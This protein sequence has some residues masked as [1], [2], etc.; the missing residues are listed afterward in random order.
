MR[1][2]FGEKLTTLPFTRGGTFLARTQIRH[3]LFWGQ[4][5]YRRQEFEKAAEIIK[6]CQEFVKKL[7]EYERT[8]KLGEWPHWGTRGLIAYFLGRVYR[9]Q[10]R[11][12]EA[13]A[14]FEESIYCYYQRARDSNAAMAAAYSHYRVAKA[15]ALGVGW[16]KIAEGHFRAALRQNLIP[17]SVLLKST[18]D[19]LNQ[20]RVLLLEV[21][22]ERALAGA[23]QAALMGIV[24]TLQTAMG[25]FHGHPHY[26]AKAARELCLAHVDLGQ[27]EDADAALRAFLA[28]RS[29]VSYE[30]EHQILS[31]L[32]A[33]GRFEKLGGAP[34]NASAAVD[35]AVKAL[36][37][38]RHVLERIEANITLGRAYFAA[39]DFE[40]AM[41]SL[42]EALDALE[43]PPA[44]KSRPNT[45]SAACYLHLARTFAKLNQA[46]QANRYLS[47]WQEIA[48]QVEHG[49]L[50][51]LADQVSREVADAGG[52]VIAPTDN[53]LDYKSRK[54]QLSSSVS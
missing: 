48:P 15:L 8:E 37:L 54:H 1:Q 16:V 53:F 6:F 40:K 31:S 4:V 33:L 36:A 2:S 49:A 24:K 44:G 34:A 20:Q 38:A 18:Q 7:H 14:A 45:S 19:E 30:C 23:D 11:L 3:V 12:N 35:H 9:H 17:A 29:G 28:A 13:A 43:P 51:Q 42:G 52:F 26:T 32:V 10:N 21:T 41:G 22:A 27:F 47:R 46:E 25:K 50:L 39:N 5:E